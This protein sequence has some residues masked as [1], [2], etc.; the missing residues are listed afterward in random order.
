MKR[1]AYTIDHLREKQRDGQSKSF[2][3][4]RIEHTFTTLRQKKR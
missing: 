2:E 3:G 4:A 1:Q